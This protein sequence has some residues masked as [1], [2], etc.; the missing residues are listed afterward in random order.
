MS[1]F[2]CREWWRAPP[3]PGE[4][5]DMGSLCVANIDNEASGALKVVTG[6]L[7]GML[8]VFCPAGRDYAVDHQMLE[9]ELD[10]A[11]LQ[12]AAGHFTSNHPGTTLRCCTRAV[13]EHHLEHSAANMCHGSFATKQG[14]ESICVQSL[15]GQLSFFEVRG[16]LL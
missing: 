14:V 13:Y 8:R 3:C 16:N 4:E 6:S 2:K 9:V 12:L 5:F 15:D 10:G 11:V 1:L 7:Q